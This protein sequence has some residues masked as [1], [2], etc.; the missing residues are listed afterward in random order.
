VPERL[1][2][3]LKRRTKVIGVLPNE[4][5]AATLATEIILRNSEQW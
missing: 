4:K 3:E 5:S 2:K 1:F